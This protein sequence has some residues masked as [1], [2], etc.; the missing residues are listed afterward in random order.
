MV[1]SAPPSLR[2]CAFSVSVHQMDLAGFHQRQQWS[3]VVADSEN[4][5]QSKSDAATWEDVCGGGEREGG[6]L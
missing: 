3:R 2:V 1:A 5:W 4:T 6:R